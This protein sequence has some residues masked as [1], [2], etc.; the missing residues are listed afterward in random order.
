MS[1]RLE[2]LGIVE[3]AVF[4]ARRALTLVGINQNIVY[5]DSLP[6]PYQTNIVVMAADDAEGEAAGPASGSIS[7]EIRDP[8][9]ERISSTSNKVVVERVH[10][11]VPGSVV[12]VAL[13][14]IQLSQYGRYRIT[15]D[16]TSVGS[17]EPSSRLHRDIFAIPKGSGDS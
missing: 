17:A 11:D 13:I 10:K 8:A 2:W 7:I 3:G 12:A 4:D 15:A 16:L 14:A 9:G 1:L 6:T 5:A